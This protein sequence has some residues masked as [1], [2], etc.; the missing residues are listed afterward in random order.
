MNTGIDGQHPRVG[1]VR[2]SLGQQVHSLEVVLSSAFSRPS[3][4]EES[5]SYPAGNLRAFCSTCN[6]LLTVDCNF[7]FQKLC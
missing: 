1:L 4:S 5:A 6:L 3:L 2:F 7:K